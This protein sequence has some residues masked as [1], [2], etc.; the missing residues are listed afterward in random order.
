MK[1]GFVGDIYVC[2]SVPVVGDGSK[3]EGIEQGT[4][5]GRV[6]SIWTVTGIAL[7]RPFSLAIVGNA[8]CQGVQVGGER[9]G[10]Q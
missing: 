5:G 4:V 6:W 10:G 8:T 9:E 7:N 1:D 2:V 3:D